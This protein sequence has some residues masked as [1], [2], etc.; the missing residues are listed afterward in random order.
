MV[1]VCAARTRAGAMCAALGAGGERRPERIDGMNLFRK[2]RYLSNGGG[3]R[4]QAIDN[5]YSVLPRTNAATQR[6]SSVERYF[7]LRKKLARKPVHNEKCARMN[8]S[9][10]W[11]LYKRVAKYVF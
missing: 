4:C 10:I 2:T 1:N 3:G 5:R 8:R 9:K 11:T 7:H 6:I